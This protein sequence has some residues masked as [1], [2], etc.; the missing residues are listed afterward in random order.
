M[1]NS[2]FLIENEIQFQYLQDTVSR[3][4]GQRRESRTAAIYITRGNGALNGRGVGA[5]L[6]CGG[7]TVF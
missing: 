5:V 2:R 7:L 3:R 6:W 1:E 4:R